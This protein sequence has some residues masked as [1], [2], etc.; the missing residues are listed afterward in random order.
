[1]GE[2]WFVVPMCSGF[3]VR[4]VCGFAV[5]RDFGEDRWPS[6]R[7]QLGLVVEVIFFIYSKYCMRNTVF[8]YPFG[9]WIRYLF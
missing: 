4:T 1:M 7:G 3:G 5:R 9:L 6:A 2:S 8:P